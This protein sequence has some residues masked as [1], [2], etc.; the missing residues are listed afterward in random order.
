MTKIRTTDT[1]RSALNRAVWDA[2]AAVGAQVG[3]SLEQRRS[4]FLR[5]LRRTMGPAQFQHL[6]AHCEE[7][8]RVAANLARLMCL[9]E[10]AVGRVRLVGLV[11][12]LGKALVADEVLGKVGPLTPAE[13]EVLGRHAEQGA[14]LCRR[15]G[16]D[17]EIADA[18]RHHH[19]RYDA[20]EAPL[21]AQ[22]VCVAD[23]LVTMTSDRP[24]SAARSFSEALAELRLG[25]G[26]QFNPEAVT[27][28]HVY[29]AT[30][31]ARAA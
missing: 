1:A 14:R 22:I 7:V 20:N 10:A 17:E 16:A 3:L 9:G 6:T 26:S 5:A 2:A 19:T 11:H 23:A 30:A 13:R 28:A 12:D 27:A 15:I 31:M 24:Y 18:V 21:L 4:R 8:S 29:G 25:R